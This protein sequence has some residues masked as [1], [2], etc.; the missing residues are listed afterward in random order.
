MVRDAELIRFLRN[1]HQSFATDSITERIAG[2]IPD[3]ERKIEKLKSE[4]R[5][6][7]AREKLQRAKAVN[8]EISKMQEHIKKTQAII[9]KMQEVLAT[10]DYAAAIAV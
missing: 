5:Q 7:P 1:N 8:A 6:L 4:F 10:D 9:L 3:Q 2:I